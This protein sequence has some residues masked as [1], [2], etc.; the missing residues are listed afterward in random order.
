MYNSAIEGNFTP[1]NGV[2]NL[3]VARQNGSCYWNFNYVNGNAVYSI[4]S[5]STVLPN[6]WYL[7]ELKAVRGAGNGEAHFYLNDEEILNATGL[8]NNHNNGIDHVSVGGG[9][10]AD[11][12]VSWYCASA[13]ASTQYIGP[14]QPLT[15]D[16]LSLVSQVASKA[17]EIEALIAY[18]AIL[19]LFS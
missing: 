6:V 8:T 7:V 19:S 4:N 2:C 1:A 11:Q 10:T 3:N 9:V 14:Q 16:T 17:V 12:P 15:A 18:Q 5:T 13:I